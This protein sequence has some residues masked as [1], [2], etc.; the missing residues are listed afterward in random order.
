MDL[1]TLLAASHFECLVGV[2]TW[3]RVQPHGLA[4]PQHVSREETRYAQL[5]DGHQTANCISKRRREKLAKNG[6]EDVSVACE[7]RLFLCRDFKLL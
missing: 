6:P 7:V 5:N 3:R 4:P 2:Y 1:G